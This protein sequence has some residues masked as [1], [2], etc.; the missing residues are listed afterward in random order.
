MSQFEQTLMQASIGK[1]EVEQL[2]FGLTSLQDYKLGAKK[3]QSRLNTGTVMH[4]NTAS[5]VYND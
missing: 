5:K 4:V 3:V 1:A 2:G